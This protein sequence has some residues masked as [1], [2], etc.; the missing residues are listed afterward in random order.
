MHGKI[1]AR[2]DHEAHDLR[3]ILYY[4]A[5]DSGTIITVQTLVVSGLNMPEM[6]LSVLPEELVEYHSVWCLACRL[7]CFCPQVSVAVLI[8]SECREVS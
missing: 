8:R 2:S 3:R 7:S 1:K 5:V 6:E 4:C